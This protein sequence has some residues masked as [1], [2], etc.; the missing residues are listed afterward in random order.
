M[1]NYLI[2][3]DITACPRCRRRTRPTHFNGCKNCGVLLFHRPI[4]FEKFEA[5]QGIRDWYLMT[6]LKGWVHR[7]HFMCKDA[8]PL[9]RDYV[10]PKLPDDYGKTETPDS[11]QAKG[12]ARKLR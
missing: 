2:Q 3:S 12:A 1:P 6:P 5:E 8:A 4:D 7:D 9:D 10:A 11:V